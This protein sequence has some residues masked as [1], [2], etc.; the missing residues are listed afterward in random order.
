[1]CEIA[2][3]RLYLPITTL[4]INEPNSTF[5][6]QRVANGYESKTQV[7]AAYKWLTSGLKIHMVWKWRGGKRY[8]MQVEMAR[9]NV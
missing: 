2:I 3:V 4:N 5:K 7:Y 9:K 8:S 1:M 6:R